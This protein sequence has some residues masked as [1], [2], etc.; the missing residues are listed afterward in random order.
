MK[1]ALALAAHPD[2]IELLMAGSLIL[3]KQAGYEIHYW[4][5]A[6][7]CCGSTRHDRNSIAQIRRDEARNACKRI[8]ATWHPPLVGDLE[9]FYDQK[10][11]ARVASVI[12]DISPQIILTHSPSD[13]MED[14]TNTS[15]LAVTAAFSRGMPN[16]QVD[17]PRGISDGPVTLYHAQ[18]YGHRDQLRKLVRP[19]IFVDV[20]SV[21]EQKTAM[22][23]DHKSQKLW[24]DES[25]GLD[26][27]LITMRE[28]DEQA[29]RMSGRYKQAEGWRR[30]LHLG[31]CEPDD[32]PLSEALAEFSFIDEGYEL[33]EV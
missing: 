27:Y 5:L 29:G 4:N 18:P 1:I 23:A 6:N 32:D 11:L 15:R 17:P 12:R 21:H 24:L 9:V 30:H 22:L 13:Y 26:S 16:F 8:G 28:L 14:H 2:D 19:E 33:G 10:M 7:G 20:A 25:Q 3:L 31:F